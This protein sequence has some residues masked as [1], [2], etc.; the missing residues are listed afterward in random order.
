VAQ[1]VESEQHVGHHHR[2]VGHADVVRV[3]LAHARLGRSGEV[4]A[5]HAHGA[6]GERGQPLQRGDPVAGELGVHQPVRVAVHAALDPDDRTRAEAEERPA[7]HLLAL[8]GGLEQEG[9]PVAAQ[10]EI[11]GH[12]RLAVRDVRVAQRHQRV[13]ASQLAHLVQRR[14]EVEVNGDG[15]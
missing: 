2:E 1:V 12:R 13:L 7:P 3:G 14:R 6:A 15:H 10:L 9:R 8:L 5:E 4:V 11:G